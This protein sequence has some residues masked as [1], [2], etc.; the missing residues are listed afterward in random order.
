MTDK[1]TIEINIVGTNNEHTE[2]LALLI[3]DFLETTGFS[4]N[5]GLA[6]SPSDEHLA[7]IFGIFEQK[8]LNC[9]TDSIINVRA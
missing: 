6:E 1:Q 8:I 4:T 9:A 7:D 2:V 5:I 3:A